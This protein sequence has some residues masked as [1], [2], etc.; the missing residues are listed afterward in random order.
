MILNGPAH[1]EQHF[2]THMKTMKKYLIHILSSGVFFKDI[3]AYDESYAAAIL[4][5]DRDSKPE[6]LTGYSQILQVSFQDVEDS[7]S[8]E[9]FNEKHGEMIRSF[10]AHLPENV[11]DLYVCCTAGESRSPAVAAAVLRASGRDDRDVWMNPFYHPNVL[12]Y[13]MLCQSFGINNSVQELER[14]VLLN[15]KA[16]KDAQDNHGATRYERWQLLE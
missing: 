3:D 1:T 4:C 11:T 5:G 16:F 6:M 14:L 9:A 7:S 2:R 13:N 8:G 10:I 15:K 12:V